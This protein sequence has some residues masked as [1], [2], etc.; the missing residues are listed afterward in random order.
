MKTVI[1]KRHLYEVYFIPRNHKRATKRDIEA[2]LKLNHPCFSPNTFIDRKSRTVCGTKY[3]MV[4]VFEKTR[5]SLF[6]HFTTPVAIFSASSLASSDCAIQC[7][8]ETLYLDD[9]PR[10]IPE[11]RHVDAQRQFDTDESIIEFAKKEK[12]KSWF[13]CPGKKFYQFSKAIVIAIA[14]IIALFGITLSVF[15]K[16]PVVPTSDSP[17]TESHGTESHIGSRPTPV[18]ETFSFCHFFALE[19]AAI[20][21]AGSKISEYRYD[22]ELKPSTTISLNGGSPEVVQEKLQF[23]SRNNEVSIPSITY[24]EKIPLFTAMFEI[25]VFE[26]SQTETLEKKHAQ[27]LNEVALFH[28]FCKQKNY[29]ISSII[30]MPKA[31]YLLS[32]QNRQLPQFLPNLEKYCLSQHLDISALDILRLSESDTFTASIQFIPKTGISIDQETLFSPEVIKTVF[33]ILIKQ[34][35]IPEQQIRDLLIGKIEDTES[36]SIVFRKTDTGKTYI[37]GDMME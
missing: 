36:Q 15:S 13:F 9:N 6:S 10:S 32:L 26:I 8:D 4:T 25:P 28:A 20:Q 3:D 16:E 1:L 30:T 19:L 7:P 21:N 17:V 31:K 5:L 29:A 12:I 37:Q 23:F 2:Y 27:S 14:C 22:S 34:K 24:A 11:S 35:T 18:Q 33:G